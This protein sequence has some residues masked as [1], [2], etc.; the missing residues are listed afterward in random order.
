MF[1]RSRLFIPIIHMSCNHTFVHQMQNLIEWVDTDA[2]H[3]EKDALLDSI[4]IRVLV[5][6]QKF[7]AYPH[8]HNFSLMPQPKDA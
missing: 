5:M 3:L 7:I 1:I 6:A 4:R 8:C 2:R